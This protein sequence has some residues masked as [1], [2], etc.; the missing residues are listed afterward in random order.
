MDCLEKTK[1][2]QKHKL[3][4]FIQNLWLLMIDTW[5]LVQPTSM[6]EAYW[7]QETLNWQ[8]SLKIQ[9]VV[10]EKDQS[11]SSDAEYLKSI[12]EWAKETVEI[13][14]VIGKNWVR[15]EKTTQKFTDKYLAVTLIIQPL[16]M[17]MLQDF[18]KKPIQVYIGRKLVTYMHTMYNGQL[19]F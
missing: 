15:L 17:Q 18:K 3:F 9:M 16:A 7:E 13:W 14:M 10:M 12:L 4:T 19:I 8:W 11:S 1:T 2:F 6:I 5:L